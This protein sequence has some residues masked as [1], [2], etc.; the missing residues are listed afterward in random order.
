MSDGKS[1]AK[2]VLIFVVFFFFTYN[3]Y[4]L[5]PHSVNSELNFLELDVIAREGRGACE[6]ISLCHFNS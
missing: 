4:R 2:Q 5:Y 6:E 1:E 3:F